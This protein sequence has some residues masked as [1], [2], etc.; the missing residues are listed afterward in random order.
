MTENKAT[1]RALSWRCPYGALIFFDFLPMAY[2]MG[3]ILT[4]LRG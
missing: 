1:I 3:Y 4:P 2:A